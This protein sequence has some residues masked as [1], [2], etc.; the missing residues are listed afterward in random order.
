[1]LA[2]PLVALTSAREAFFTFGDATLVAVFVV[3]WLLPISVS[4]TSAPG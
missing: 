1:M 4:K 3:W 2:D